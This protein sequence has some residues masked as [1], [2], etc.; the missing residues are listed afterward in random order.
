[1]YYSLYLKVDSCVKRKINSG[2]LWIKAS[3]KE[4]MFCFV[5]RFLLSSCLHYTGGVSQC[6]GHLLGSTCLPSH[7]LQKRSKNPS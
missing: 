2:A 5:C 3:I 1:M 7:L 4:H 6:R